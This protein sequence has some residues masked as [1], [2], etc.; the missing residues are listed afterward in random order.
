[1]GAMGASTMAT[2]L[3]G[4][5]FAVT[6][7]SAK[8]NQAAAG[9]FGGDLVNVANMFG[10]VVGATGGL[11]GGA[12][13]AAAGEFGATS[14]DPTAA[15]YAN[16]ADLASDAV[17]NAGSF[18]PLAQMQ[19]AS[20]DAA[21]S[22]GGPGGEFNSQLE[23]INQMGGDTQGMGAQPAASG[24]QVTPVNAQTPMDLLNSGS[25]NG[26]LPANLMPASGQGAAGASAVGAG[27]GAAGTDA[28]STQ[29]A[30][31]ASD[32][33]SIGGPAAVQA[34]GAGD[35]GPSWLQRLGMTDAKGNMT[36][37]GVRMAGAVVGGVGQGYTAAQKLAEEK[38]QFD[39]KMATMNQK[40]G[41]R[42]TR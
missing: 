6:G 32:Q 19:T 41:V 29:A 2:A 37:G 14:T 16:S 24:T 8:I 35:S 10:T 23:G 9:V 36:P 20:D 34:P 5:A 15:N 7:I 28:A 31:A 12:G 17:T 42:V 40:T 18:G 38:R 30:A 22:M 3:T 1:M 13:D 39:A 4:I 25:P 27:S 21:S 33:G 26:Q 11:P